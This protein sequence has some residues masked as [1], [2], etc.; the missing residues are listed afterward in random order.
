MQ[1]NVPDFPKIAPL[2]KAKAKAGTN[3]D[4]E[5]LDSHLENLRSIGEEE[6]Y[7]EE[8]T[9][10]TRVSQ[11]SAS[12]TAAAPRGVASGS[13]MPVRSSASR[14]SAESEPLQSGP[15]SDVE[16]VD[17]SSTPTPAAAINR[18]MQ[19]FR[20]ESGVQPIPKRKLNF[21]AKTMIENHHTVRNLHFLSKYSTLIS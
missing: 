5:S 3:D 8:D 10:V 1:N 21:C 16:E 20:E 17:Q 19:N 18:A 11:I 2:P 6:D 13:G 9:I 7:E 14:D 4:S 12:G 15:P